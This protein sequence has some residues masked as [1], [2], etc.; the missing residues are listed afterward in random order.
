MDFPNLHNRTF[1]VPFYRKVRKRYITEIST[2]I[3]E[4]IT[5]IYFSFAAYIVL[6]L[7]Y[8][9]WT[10][11]RYVIPYIFFVIFTIVLLIYL[12]DIQNK[13]I[14]MIQVGI[15]GITFASNFLRWILYLNRASIVMIWG[16]SMYS[17]ICFFI[18]QEKGI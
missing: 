9:T 12:L 16:I 6:S 11:Y 15:L 4:V 7:F 5:G 10:N 17:I 3:T 18:L 14:V 13:L 2:E 1:V 8:I